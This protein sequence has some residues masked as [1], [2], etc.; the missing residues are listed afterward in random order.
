LTI[1]PAIVDTFEVVGVV[2]NNLPASLKKTKLQMKF[3][4]GQLIHQHQVVN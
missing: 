1:G 2:G 3:H 4:F